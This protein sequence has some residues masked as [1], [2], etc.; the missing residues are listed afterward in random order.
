MAAD[1]HFAIH[2]GRGGEILDELEERT[3]ELPYLS[4]DPERA[5]YLN[6]ADVGAGGFDAILDEIAPDWRKHLSHTP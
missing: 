5:Y 4:S 1:V 2:D 6:A 3:G